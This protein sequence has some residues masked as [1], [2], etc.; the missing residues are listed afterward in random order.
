MT[1]IR[2]FLS[3]VLMGTNGVV[4]PAGSCFRILC[5]NVNVS[6]RVSFWLFLWS[7][8]NFSICTPTIF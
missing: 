1:F 5:V 8:Q 4:V 6:S 7:F 3:S 2:V